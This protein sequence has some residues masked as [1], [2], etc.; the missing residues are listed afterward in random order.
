MSV[1][2]QQQAAFILQSQ[3]KVGAACGV[4]SIAVVNFPFCPYTLQTA[5]FKVHRC[6]YYSS[7]CQLLKWLLRAAVPLFMSLDVHFIAVLVFFGDGKMKKPH[8][9]ML[10]SLAFINCVLTSVLPFCRGDISIVAGA[11]CC[12]SLSQFCCQQG[13]FTKCDDESEKI[14]SRIQLRV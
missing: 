4:C 12:P 7:P 1:L 14:C 11:H 9:L 13:D 2:L 6:C 3:E 10:C 8:V 5:Y